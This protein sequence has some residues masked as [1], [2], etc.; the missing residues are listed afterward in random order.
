MSKV[1]YIKANA[2]A[3]GESRTFRISDSFIETYRANNPADEIIELD[4]YDAGLQFL[5]KGKM[6]ELRQA[7]QSNDQNHPVLKFAYDFRNADKYVVAEPIWNLGIP[8]ILKAYIDYVAVG[9]I[10]FTY[11]ENGP[12]GLCKNKKAVNIIT[13]G[14]DYSSE[15]VESIEMADK[16]LRNIFGFMGITD[17]TTIAADRLDIFTEDTEKLVADAVGKA[18]EVALNF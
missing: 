6:M 5:P 14:G 4:L 3:E 10:T 8:A 12:V 11:T 18:Q 1:L 9:G 15:P 2:K 7:V 17:Y 16:Y 13:R